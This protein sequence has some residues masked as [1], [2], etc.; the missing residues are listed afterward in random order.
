MRLWPFQI[1]GLRTPT[2]AERL[3]V[4]VVLIVVCLVAGV[5]CLAAGL[6]TAGANAEQASRLR[7]AG[8]VLLVTGVAGWLVGRLVGRWQDDL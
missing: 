5:I 6:L 1:L 4:R 8:V 7:A 3:I 2:S